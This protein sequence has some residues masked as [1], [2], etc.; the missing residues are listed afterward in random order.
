MDKDAIFTEVYGTE[1]KNIQD[2]YLGWL[3]VKKSI[4]K[5]KN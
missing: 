2:S 1:V 3:I 4:Q 5:K